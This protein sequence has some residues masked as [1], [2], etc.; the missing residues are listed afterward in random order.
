MLRLR[1]GS[2]S[3][4]PGIHVRKIKIDKQFYPLNAS[5]IIEFAKSALLNKSKPVCDNVDIEMIY[6]DKE[7]IV[8][9]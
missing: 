6:K 8:E 7:R 3:K 5:K 2:S 1:S 4:V 9:E